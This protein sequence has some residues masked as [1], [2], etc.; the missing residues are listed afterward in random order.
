MPALSACA[1]YWREPPATPPATDQ[2]TFLAMALEADAGAREA[3]WKSAAAAR[4]SDDAALRVALLQ[5]LPG[6]SGYDPAAAHDALQRLAARA[7]A[8][9]VAAVAR[10]RLASVDQDAAMTAEIAQLRQRLA[11][12]VEIEKRMKESGK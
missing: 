11:R 6:H 8:P 1:S 5:S 7:T 2:V 4:A 9:Q 12:V 10:M 3:L